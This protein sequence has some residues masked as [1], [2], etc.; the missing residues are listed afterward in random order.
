MCTYNS[1][2]NFIFQ[3]SNKERILLTKNKK[4][5]IFNQEILLTKLNKKIIYQE[6]TILQSLYKSAIDK[7]I[8]A[9]TINKIAIFHSC[10]IE[11]RI[12]ERPQHKD[13]I[14]IKFGINLT[15]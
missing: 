3:I 15:R 4:E 2:K 13:K 8:P 14:V 5:N 1:I 9:N 12:D 11:K 7:K 6:N 10:K